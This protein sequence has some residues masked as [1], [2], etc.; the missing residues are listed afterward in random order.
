MLRTQRFLI[1]LA[2]AFLVSGCG[3][4]T[5]PVPPQ[6]VLP[7]AIEDLAYL[8]DEK[9]VTLTWTVPKNTEAGEKLSGVDEFELVRA[10][11]PEDEHCAGCPL[12][13]DTP[14]EIEVMPVSGSKVSFSEALLRPGY[15]RC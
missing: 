14:R 4:K 13:F 9:G 12:N 10:L 7:A 2:V 15:L 11:V 6:T 8:L 1:L 5:L 3:K